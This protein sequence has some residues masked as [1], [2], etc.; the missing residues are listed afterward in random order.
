MYVDILI[1]AHLAHEP[2]HGYEIKKRVA[3]ILGGSIVLNNN[4]L[5]PA[6]RRFEEMGA[7]RRTVEHQQGKPNRNVYTLTE[8]GGDVLQRLLQDFPPELARDGTEFITRVAFFHLLD[9]AARL[10]ILARR[11]TALSEHRAHLQQM[12]ALARDDPGMYSASVIAFLADQIERELEWIAML[13][14]REQRDARSAA[15]SP[16]QDET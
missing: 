14:Q 9:P 10:G 13:T 8:A 1:L 11:R 2:Q 16:T 12:A 6:L 15:P 5:Y 4:L 3:R 7:V